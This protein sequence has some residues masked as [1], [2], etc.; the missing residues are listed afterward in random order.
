MLPTKFW[1]EMSWRD[2]AAADMSKVVAVL[3]VAATE[4][5]GPHLPVGVD[6]YINQGY[7]AA[8]GQADAPAEMPV[9]YL[10]AQAIGKSNEHI[11]YPG[12]LTL[13]PAPALIRAWEEIGDSVARTG[14]RKLV[15]INS[16]RRQCAG[17]IHRSR[18]RIARE[19]RHARR[20]RRL[21]S[22]RLPGRPVLGAAS[23]PTA[24]TAATPRRRSCSRSGP[25]RCA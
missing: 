19:A 23:A 5:H 2:F 15:F 3:P 18:A 24:F 10:P 22:A 8:R 17:G 6:T 12:T 13:P 9:L 4:Q 14:C 20:S 16:P 1:A 7:L 11:E 21:A 25:R